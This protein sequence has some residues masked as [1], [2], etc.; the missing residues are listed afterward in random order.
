MR[1]PG[2]ADLVY[3]SGGE[4][5]D[6]DVADFPKLGKRMV[7]TG[8]QIDIYDV[9]DGSS[10]QLDIHV[11]AVRSLQAFFAFHAASTVGFL[12][13]RDA[14]LELLAFLG[15][16]RQVPR[17]RVIHG[18][19]IGVILRPFARA[20]L[21]LVPANAASSPLAGSHTGISLHGSTFCSSRNSVGR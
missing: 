11:R 9:A 5:R 2:P 21:L 12:L 20:A 7:R 17:Q 15:R 8:K 16:T 4:N 13:G 10:G 3:L 18:L 1:N 6:L 14:G 19:A